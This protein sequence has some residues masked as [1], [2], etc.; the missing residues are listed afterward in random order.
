MDQVNIT[1]NGHPVRA[2]AG[3]TV[4]EAAKAAGIDIP[5]LCHHPAIAPHGACRICLV[6]IEKQRTLQ[7]ACTFP[8]NEGMKVE[9]ES[10]K[11]VEERKFVLQML[12]SER[13]HYC[14]F[15]EMSGD[16]ELQSLAYRYGMDQWIYQNPFPKIPVDG[17]REYFIMDHNRCILCRRCVRACSDLVASHTL[18]VKYRGAQTMVSAD[19]DVSFGQSTCVS[20]GTCLQVCPTGAL[21]DRRSAYM[22]RNLQV[23]RT[24]STCMGCSVGCG[25]D[26]VSR[27]GRVL[28]VEG[29]WEEHNAGILCVAGRFAPFHDPRERITSPLVRRKGELVPVSWEEAL[30]TLAE[31]VKAADPS[32]VTARTTSKVLNMT[33]S[34]FVAVFQGKM[35]ADVGVLEPTLTSI[36]LPADGALADIDAADCILVA[37]SDPLEDHRVVGYRIRRALAKGTPI[38]LASDS[39]NSLAAWARATYPLKDLQEPVR[40][41]HGSRSPVVVYGTGLTPTEAHALSVL[42]RKAR[43]IPL[44]PAA[45]GYHA[46]VLGL[47]AGLEAGSSDLLYLLLGDTVQ[48]EELVRKARAARTLVVH[49]TFHGPATAAADLVLPGLQWFEWDGSF[50]NLEGKKLP[51]RKAAAPPEGMIPENEVLTQLAARL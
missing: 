21:I 12:F 18:G 29:D 31:K 26:I 3:Q 44:F 41:C 16:C 40:I 15:C 32:R 28:R 17:T 38:H 19:M 24:K 45:N 36:D 5:A 2:R 9:T 42:K 22:G 20:C 49:A 13:N 47:K 25:V 37:G 6:E 1:I 27:D 30:D 39:G 46:K 11:V 10:P 50:Y 33:L 7:P 51:V 23:E 34:E 35:G 43:F 8:V 48:K 4:L 14:M